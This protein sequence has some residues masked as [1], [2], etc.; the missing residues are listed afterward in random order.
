MKLLKPMLWWLE[1]RFDGRV[2]GGN[3]T[4]YATPAAAGTRASETPGEVEVTTDL[5]SAPPPGEVGYDYRGWPAAIRW[6][7]VGW[8]LLGLGCARL[9]VAARLL[10]P[11]AIRGA[12]WVGLVMRVEAA[13]GCSCAVMALISRRNTHLHPAFV[14]RRVTAA[15]AGFFAETWRRELSG[16]WRVRSY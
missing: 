8:R 16:I 12:M 13:A 10:G 2:C 15:E 1:R 4:V 11:T 3:E 5:P 6:R 7:G 14:D 9:G